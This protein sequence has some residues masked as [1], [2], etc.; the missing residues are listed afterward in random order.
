MGR[1]I[2]ATEARVHF[3]EIVRSANETNQPI[4]IEKAGKEVAVLLSPYEYRR[5]VETKDDDWLELVQESQRIF[6]KNRTSELER[7]AA[8]LICA[9]RKERDAQLDE[10]LR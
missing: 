8:E 5:L 3:G 6:A 2:S 10:A 1:T 7:N 4:F 9:D